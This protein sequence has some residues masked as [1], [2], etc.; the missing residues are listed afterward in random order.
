MITILITLIL[1]ACGLTPKL[2]HYPIVNHDGQGGSGPRVVIY[3]SKGDIEVTP[4]F[5]SK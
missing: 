4:I 5:S 3:T 1:N 2:S